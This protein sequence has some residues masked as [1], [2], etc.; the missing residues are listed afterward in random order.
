MIDASRVSECT[1]SILE[2]TKKLESWESLDT[3]RKLSV[4]HRD[5]L[6]ENIEVSGCTAEIHVR[7]M[8]HIKQAAIL[9]KIGGVCGFPL[10]QAEVLI[11]C[12]ATIFDLES[13][14][15]DPALVRKVPCFLCF[16][17]VCLFV[18]VVCV[19]WGCK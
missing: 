14:P 6:L 10:L 16:V 3:T 7:Q 5:K 8:T 4:M 11:G 9:Q 12:E 17:F 2:A 15:V 1:R 13:W 19:W 18:V